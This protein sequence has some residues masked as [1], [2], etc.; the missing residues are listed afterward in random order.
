MSGYV[1]AIDQGTTSS[2]AIVFDDRFRVVGLGQEEF[3]QHLPRS[4]WVEHDPEEIWRTTLSTM[5]SALAYSSLSASDLA[6]IG[7]ANQR[8]TTV[9]WDRRTGLPIHNAIVWQDRRTSEMCR[10]LV[11]EGT[12]PEITAR[13][14]LIVDPYFAGTKIAWLL[15]NVEGA[16]RL[17]E[18]G[19][20]AFGTI[21]SFLL[22]RLTGGR[23]H[24][25]DTTNASRTMLFDIEAN[26]WDA[27]LLRLLD[28]PGAVLPEVRD[29]DADFGTT[30]PS[31]F[32]VAIPIRGVAG[33]QHAAAIG[34][35]CFRPGMVKA[36]YGTGCFA[37]LN[38]G[39][40]RVASGSRMLTTV[41]YRL[42]G[43]TT[44]ALE[45]SIFVAGAA[46][47]WLRDEL[48]LISS[49]PESG[50]L[51][52]NADAEQDVV[53]VPAFTGL[54]APWWDAEARGAIFGLTRRSGPRE[55]ARAAL[56][57]TCFQTSDLLAAMR[58]DCPQASDTV[59]RVDGGMVASDWTMQRL[60]DLLDAPV[61]RPVVLET[62]ALGAAWIAGQKA[63]VWPG[64]DGFAEQWR[65]ERRFEPG[66]EGAERARRLG[67]WEDAVRRTRSTF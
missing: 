10:R 31:L 17:A 42:A 34:Q 62:T 7:I 67:L 22:W 26:A 5:R 54:G 23:V 44:Y 25:T 37:L 59:L 52:E 36:T 41:G 30:D 13:T 43:R 19:H 47:Q 29:C 3:R 53:M 12:E 55:L 39:S 50:P 33:D 20:L 27:D 14:G 56:E 1:L 64:M 66:M 15:D 60:S 4:G 11:A 46:V 8:E 21:D 61:D 57:A 32:G 63:G 49:A 58:R 48:R 24:A 2:R 16:R 28:I 51:A 65:L 6:A 45:G 40:E 38:T 9:L 18:D 35:A